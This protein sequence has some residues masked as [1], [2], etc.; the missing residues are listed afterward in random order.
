MMNV[1]SVDSGSLARAADSALMSLLAGSTDAV[2]AALRAISSF[3][4][5]SSSQL[6]LLELEEIRYA[7]Q[8]AR[9]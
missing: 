2:I 1:R 5:G 7:Y 8:P 4:L 6:R 3:S 9:R